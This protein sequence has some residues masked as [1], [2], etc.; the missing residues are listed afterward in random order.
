M[1]DSHAETQGGCR[2]PENQIGESEAAAPDRGADS[3]SRAHG[4][5][6]PLLR[7][8]SRA[9]FVGARGAARRGTRAD[10]ESSAAL[11]FAGDP[12]RKPGAGGSHVR[13]AVA[14]DLY[15]RA[16]DPVRTTRVMTNQLKVQRDPVCGMNVDPARAKATVERD[17][18]TYY[19]CCEGCAT[20]FRNDPEK[21]LKTDKPSAAEAH[22]AAHRPHSEAAAPG[23]IQPAT[24]QTKNTYVCPMD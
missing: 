22:G 13:R 6:R 20:K 17:G 23:S 2:G 18:R 10:A 4:G 24:P 16:I 11:R 5:R 12:Q 8:H 19:F 3:R 15:P 7:R 1:R 21:Y 9:D 14:S